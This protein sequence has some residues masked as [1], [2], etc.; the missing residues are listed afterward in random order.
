[1][2]QKP[3]VHILLFECP[4]CAGP[5]PTA[6]ASDHRSMEDV[7]SRLVGVTCGCGWSAEVPATDAKRHWVDSWSTRMSDAD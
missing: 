2:N 4:R 6:I 7:D 1:M 3:F 5:A